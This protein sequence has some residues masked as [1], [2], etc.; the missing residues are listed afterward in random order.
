MGY[1]RR[2]ITAGRHEPLSLRCEVDATPKDVVRFSWTYN[3]TR[4]DVLPIP[5][6]RAQNNGLVSVL[7][8]TPTADTDF[9]TL[10]CWA[11]NSIGRQRTPCIFNIL[12]GSTC[13][14]QL[15]PPTNSLKE[16]W[17]KVLLDG[18]KTVTRAAHLEDGFKS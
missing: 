16:L 7:E 4:G 14:W 17:P 5:N 12:P 8:Y 15:I 1:E 11:S 18:H 2:E 13:P 9:G 10:A 3:G 6:S